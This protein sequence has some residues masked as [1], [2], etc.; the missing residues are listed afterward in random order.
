MDGVW[1]PQQIYSE[2]T[3]HFGD[4]NVAMDV[5]NI[6]P[7]EDFREFI[8]KKIKECD[9]FLTIVGDRWTEI[10]K[11]RRDDPKDFVRIEIQTALESKKIVVPILVDNA[12]MPRK[13][14]LPLELEDFAYK[15]A[16]ELRAGP[17]FD[18]QMDRLIKELDRLLS[19]KILPKLIAVAIVIVLMTGGWYYYKDQQ[20]IHSKI[21]R[22]DNQV[23]DLETAIAKVNNQ[24]KEKLKELSIQVEIISQATRALKEQATK[25]GL[26]S[27][28]YKLQ[29]RFNLVQIQL[30]RKEK[31][32][33]T[34]ECSDYEL[35]E[36][37]NIFS[38][39]KKNYDFET[40]WF[41]L[42]SD[43]CRYK[44]MGSF[45]PTEVKINK[46]SVRIGFDIKLKS[47][48]VLCN[49]NRR[50]IRVNP[51]DRNTWGAFSADLE[52][53]TIDWDRKLKIKN[54]EYTGGGPI[55]GLDNIIKDIFSKKNNALLISQQAYPQC[56]GN[57]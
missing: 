55:S 17:D 57:Q 44:S 29:D 33:I 22:F 24:Y 54:P 52:I 18:D 35:A 2:L 1:P 45:R 53:V 20:K 25:A 42:G 49:G 23:D 41:S 50:E 27:H 40:A 26:E 51:S 46:S 48:F 9:I 47:R 38:F 43:V 6:L 14:D 31:T 13:E 32:L 7:G 56:E 15:E 37:Y 11:A 5:K 39:E 3:K 21:E 8:K 19:K 16:R 10:L 12:S 36:L 30:D 28:L 34:A 4:G